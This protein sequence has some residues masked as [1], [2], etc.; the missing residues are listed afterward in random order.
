MFCLC[1]RKVS[2]YKVV[3]FS[4]S[5]YNELIKFLVW[6]RDNG[7][8]ITKRCMN[9][10]KYVDGLKKVSHYNINKDFCG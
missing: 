5:K 1:V 10:P 2:K 8:C 4:K 9:C 7:E 3:A 6:R